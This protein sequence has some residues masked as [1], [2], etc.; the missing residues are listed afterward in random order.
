MHSFIERPGYPVV[1]GDDGFGKYEQRRFLLDGE[2]REKSDWPI[3]EVTED[4]SGH[5]VLNLSD[6]Q[7]RKRLD[8]FDSMELEEKIRLLEFGSEGWVGVFGLVD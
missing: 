5:Y 3:P 4:M 7:F 1:T 8:R 2:I 6:E